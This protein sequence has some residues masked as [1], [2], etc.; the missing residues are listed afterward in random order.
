M[1]L[2]LTYDE[3]K[4]GYI[5]EKKINHIQ[6]FVKR[7]RQHAWRTE[8]KRIEVFYVHEYGKK[9]KKHWHALVFNLDFSDKTVHTTSE[10][11][12]LYTSQELTRLWGHGFSTIGD[13]SFGSAMYQSQYMEKDFSNG[14][15]GTSK[16]SQSRHSGLAKEYFYRHYRQ[17][18]GLGY[19]PFNGNKVPLPRYFQ[20]IADRH[21][22]H[23]YEKSAF[24][25]TPQRKAKYRPFKKEEP[26]K[27]IAE[28]WVLYKLNKEEKIQELE[29]QWD[30]LISHYLTTKEAPDFIKSEQNKIHD[31]QTKNMNE[32]F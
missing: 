14:H 15:V 25:D 9:G 31:R 27:Q 23:F 1:F 16:K 22:C 19:I 30:N 3:K 8:R 2:T 24:F 28:M 10:G 6:K 12:P 32:R 20:K 17:L 7:L 21:Y 5:N 26:N 4:Q 13:V 18:L 11:L 29:K